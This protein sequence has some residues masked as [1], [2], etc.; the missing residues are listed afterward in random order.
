MAPVDLKPVLQ[1]QLT[2]TSCSFSVGAFGAVAEFFRREDEQHSVD[3]KEPLTVSTERGAIRI[4]LHDDIL[5]VA[6]ETLSSR[7]N[8]WLHGLALCLPSVHGKSSGRSSVTELGCDVDAIRPEDR[9]D[10]LF[11]I[12]VGATN[13]DFCIRT[14][15]PDLIDV[16]RRAAGKSLLNE[17]NDTMLKIIAASPH[18]IVSC[19]LGRIEVYQSIGHERT[20]EGPHTHVLP[21][22]LRSGRTHDAKIP[23]PN[24]YLPCVSVYPASPLFDELGEPRAYDR[25]SHLAFEALLNKWGS[26]EYVAQKDQVSRSIL[27]EVE[28]ESFSLPGTRLRRSAL[29]I[30]L[31]QL[32]R[33]RAL[34]ERVSHW[35]ARFDPEH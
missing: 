22:L 26:K 20:P 2:D 29:R 31:R 5:P 24:G 25:A 11:D 12:G 35:R 7:K 3:S 10:L 6:Y 1:A 13:I 17:G 14:H 28:P 30:A 21:K 34:S 19:R 9:R 15:D 33:D 32:A 4:C 27:D 18:R 8:F 16:L 23:I